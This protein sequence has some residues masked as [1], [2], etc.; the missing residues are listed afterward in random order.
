MN[1]V[2]I[3]L[4]GLVLLALWLAWRQVRV[5]REI[6]RVAEAPPASLQ[7][8]QREVQ[9]MRSGVDERLREHLEQTGELS[10]RIGLLQKATDN[11]EQ[12]GIGLGELQKILQPPQLRGAFG[13]RM[14]E[15]TLADMLPCDRFRLQYTY[16][17]SGARV[18]AAVILGDD[19]LLPIDS[20][21]P[22]DNFRRYVDLRGSGSPEADSARRSFARDVRGH[23]DD[24]AAKYIAPDE[25]AIDVAFMYIPS[26]SVFHEVAIDPLDEDGRSLT[27]YAFRKR[28]IPVSPNTLHAYLT[29]VRMGLRGFQL[30]ESAREILQHLS[31]LQSDVEVLRSELDTALKQARHS[32]TNL[33][34]AD[35]ALGRVEGRLGSIGTEGTGEPAGAAGP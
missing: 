24:I 35:A 19:R 10:R 15:E 11:V 17:G 25:G 26:E 5:E 28:V 27:E 18:D 14:L 3:L 8:L 33:S 12:L 20:K 31:H 32:L 7:L 21:F 29:V 4:A 6:R 9:A 1:H 2:T 22:L 30:Q 23:I 34:D 13:E 16:P